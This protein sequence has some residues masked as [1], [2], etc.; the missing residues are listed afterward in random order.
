PVI[1]EL[2]PYF[3]NLKVKKIKK[4]TRGNPLTGYLFT[5]K[6]EQ[7]QPWIENKYDDQP[8]EYAPKY[9][10]RFTEWL[11]YYVVLSTHDHELIEQFKLDVYQIFKQHA[12]I[13]TNYTVE[14]HNLYIAIS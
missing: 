14:Y 1:K 5:W 9:E 6:P 2:S 13:A 8:Q 3:K 11:I 10:D 12:Y 7:T 4:N